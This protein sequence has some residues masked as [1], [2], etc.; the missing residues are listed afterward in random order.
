MQVVRR[1]REMFYIHGIW[2]FILQATLGG[3][4]ET[5]FPRGNARQEKPSVEV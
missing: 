4:K 2:S 3:S 1:L 5:P